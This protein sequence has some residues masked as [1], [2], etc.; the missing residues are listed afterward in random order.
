MRKEQ[1]SNSINEQYLF[2]ACGL[3]LAIS[4]ISGRWKT[5]IL[6]SIVRGHNRFNLLHKKIDNISEQVLGRQLKALEKDNIIT[7]AI[8]PD[9]IPIGVEYRL[10]DLGIELL[11]ILNAL[12]DWGKHYR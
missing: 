6:L 9:S 10:T 2:N 4:K 7:K 5:Q 8:I 1:S 11:P 12:C 3:N